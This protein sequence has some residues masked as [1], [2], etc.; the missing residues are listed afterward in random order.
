VR[1]WEEGNIAWRAELLGAVIERV[2]V[3][4]A[5]RGARFDPAR[6]GIVWR[7]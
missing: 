3:A 2:D 1:R 6:V 4:P 5:R 7:A